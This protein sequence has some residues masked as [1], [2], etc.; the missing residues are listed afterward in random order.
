MV[1]NGIGHGTF[2]HCEGGDGLR[3]CA[4]E[5]CALAFQ[6]FEMINGGAKEN[7]KSVVHRLYFNRHW[8][9]RSNDEGFA[10]YWASYSQSKLAI[11]NGSLTL[12]GRIT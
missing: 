7:V 2:W 11:A 10:G 12:R 3:I 9:A 1:W 5:F 6:V 8:P 4:N